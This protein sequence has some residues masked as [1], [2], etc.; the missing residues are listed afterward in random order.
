M[1]GKFGEKIVLFR[2]LEALDDSRSLF[3]HKASNY[4]TTSWKTVND[5]LLL[6]D[7]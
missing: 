2:E 7:V 3:Y 5:F 1:V 6:L 4:Y